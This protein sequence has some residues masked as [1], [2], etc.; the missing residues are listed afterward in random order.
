MTAEMNA[1]QRMLAQQIMA[2]QVPEARATTERIGAAAGPVLAEMAKQPKSAVRLLVL[3]LAPLAPSPDG[4]RA[5]IGLLGDSNSTVRA[6]AKSDLAVCFQKEVVP[7]LVR[8]LESKPD[9]EVTAALIL[10]IG[11]AG[12]K[13][14]IPTLQRYLRDPDKQVSHAASNAMARLG[15]AAQRGR[16]IADLKNPDPPVRVQA[17]RDCQYV[18]DKSL[19]REFGL[20]LDDT[21]DFMMSTPP[22]IEPVVWVRV[23]D[24]AVQT[25]AYMGFQ[26]SFQAQFLERRSWPELLEAKKLAETAPAQ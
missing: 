14:H 21:R 19:A 25:M 8:A 18:S 23:C 9:G 24:I 13:S 2:Q 3:E 26:F 10:Q 12:D 20:A 6:V 16:I 7:D 17:L 5:V 4:A 1:D 15:D 22:H 11:I